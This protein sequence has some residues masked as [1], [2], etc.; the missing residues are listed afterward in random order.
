MQ[1]LIRFSAR[2]GWEN[3]PSLTPPTDDHHRVLTARRRRPKRNAPAYEAGALSGGPISC[4]FVG[5]LG[6]AVQSVN[7]PPGE[8]PVVA[9]GGVPDAEEN[10]AD[11]AHTR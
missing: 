10:G 5:H 1:Q 3:G 11:L 8:F 2:S 7:D 4:L 9:D 6:R